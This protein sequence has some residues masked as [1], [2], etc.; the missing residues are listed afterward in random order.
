[1]YHAFRGQTF[2]KIISRIG[3]IRSLLPSKVPILALTATV[4]KIN[5]AEITRSLGLTNELLVTKSPSKSNIFYNKSFFVSI[6]YNFGPLLERLSAERLCFPRT[7]IYCQKCEDCADIFLYFQNNLGC[8]F[9]EPP[10]SP[11]SIPRYRM[12][13]MF[14]SS[15]EEYVKEEIIKAFT[16]DAPLRIV[17]ATVAFGMGID[18]KDVC[19]VI[20]FQPSPD[21]ELY[22]QEVG[23]V[24][25]NGKSSTA[26]L[27]HTKKYKRLDKDM[28]EYV[29][30][31]TICRRD[32]LFRN[33]DGYEHP[34]ELNNCLCCDIC[35]K[36]CKC[37]NCK[38]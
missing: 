8:C 12:V 35:S 26:L 27:L 29:M 18:C 23:R 19:Q 31:E 33:F 34:V 24:G 4:T 28:K 7:I 32:I 20:H 37:S 9:T 3:E 13:D 25:R 22:V 17:I 21:V 30:N 15:T 2:R 10:N 5:R 11:H 1:M 38:I 14:M 36:S 6:E 16:T